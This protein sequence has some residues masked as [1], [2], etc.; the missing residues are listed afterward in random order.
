MLLEF[1]CSNHKSIRNEV[2]FS[3]MAG[4]DNT[5][6]EKTKEIPGGRV[7]KSAIIYGANG[8]GKS[9]LID[10]I[11]FVKNLVV[12]SINHQPGQGIRQIPHKLDGFSADSTYRIQFVTQN[13]RY[14]FGFSLRNMLVSDEYLYYF[15]NN[16]QT[17][18]YERTAKSLA[19]AINSVGNLAHVKMFLNPTVFCSLVQLILAP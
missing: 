15:P 13:I 7:L 12:N 2:L 10:A 9:N 18:I 3:A 5:F 14:V 1:A 8:A 17:K 11:S 6:E 4:K 19:L 16:R